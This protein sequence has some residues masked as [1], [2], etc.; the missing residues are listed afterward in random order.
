M[1]TPGRHVK[2]PSN[3]LLQNSDK[4]GTHSPIY[5]PSTEMALGNLGLSAQALVL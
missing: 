4:W 1:K 2:S 3:K 5:V